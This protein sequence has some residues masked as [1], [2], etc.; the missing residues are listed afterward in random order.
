LEK[1]IASFFKKDVG[2]RI[3][4]ADDAG[5]I[6]HAF[7]FRRHIPNSW[8]DAAVEAIEALRSA[9]DQC[10]Y[11]IAVRSGVAEPKHAYF[12]FADNVVDLDANVKRACA[13][14]PQEIRN[15]FRSFNSYKEGNYSL[16]AL[17]KLCNANKHRL[18]IPVGV[19]S[20]GMELKQLEG[21]GPFQIPSPV[22]DRDKNQIV[23]ATVEPGGSLKFDV[24]LSFFVAFDDFNG[25]TGGPAV[26]ILDLI[27]SEVDRVLRASEAQCRTIGLIN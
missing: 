5:K 27:A 22:W 26:G 14:L 3:S 7:R 25:V 10:G 8:S 15:L 19:A 24:N 4:E 21:R 1:R 9:L 20:A 18:L 17:N 2:D 11:A 6:I 23:I 13:D 16:W 12:P